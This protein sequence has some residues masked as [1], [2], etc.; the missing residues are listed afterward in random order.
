M[1]KTLSISA[2]LLGSL[3]LSSFAFASGAEVRFGE[4]T[5]GTKYVYASNLGVWTDYRACNNFFRS[6]KC[7]GYKACSD[8]IYYPGIQKRIRDYLRQGGR[9]IVVIKTPRTNCRVTPAR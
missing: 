1:L 9:K 7:E 3:L 2:C 8:T 5:T 6:S 4:R